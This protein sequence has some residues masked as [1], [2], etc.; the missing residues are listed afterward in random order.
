MVYSHF[1]NDVR[2]LEVGGGTG[3]ENFVSNHAFDKLS[4]YGICA[5]KISRSTINLKSE[6]GYEPFY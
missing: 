4:Q 5:R 2:L 1:K 6:F 3:A